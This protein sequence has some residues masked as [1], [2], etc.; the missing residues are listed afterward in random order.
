[1]SVIITP[2][3]IIE[4]VLLKKLPKE[5]FKWFDNQTEKY[6]LSTVFIILLFGFLMVSLSPFSNLNWLYT[7][8]IVLIYLSGLTGFFYYLY[9]I[10]EE[11]KKL[12]DAE[13]DY[14]QPIVKRF[15]EDLELIQDLVATSDV[16]HLTYARDLF[17]QRLNHLKARTA[18]MVGAIDKVGVLPLAF[19]VYKTWPSL[20]KQA[21]GLPVDYAI[22]LVFGIMLYA[23]VIKINM[24][25]QWMEGVA[26]VFKQAAEIKERQEKQKT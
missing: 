18:L 21:N 20:Q 19:L 22:I 5:K 2:Q 8:G 13:I 4:K 3:S 12:T 23:L 16:H 25:S 10:R 6:T 14:S 17:Q 24:V 11:S 7:C 26:L 9:F 15:N 1:M